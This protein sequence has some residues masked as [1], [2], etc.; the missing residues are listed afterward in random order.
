MLLGRKN[1]YK[2]LEK[3]LGYSFRKRAFLELALMHRSF[4]F[5]SEAVGM[6]NQRLEFLGD[7]VLGF[8]AAEYL[9]EASRDMDEGGLTAFRSRATSGKTLARLAQDV[10]LGDYIKIGKGEE[11]T[12]GRTRPSNLEDALESVLGA[13][14]LDG[15]MK[16][17]RKIF[18]RVFVPAMPDLSE[19]VWAGNPKG[20]LQEC[21]QRVWKRSPLYRIVTREGPPHAALFT[22]EVTIGEGLRGVGKGR[23]KQEAE[24][25]AAR[26]LL[27]QLPDRHRASP[28]R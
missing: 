18:Q 6:D 3:R 2:D 22:A 16:A 17:V 27:E 26:D 7:A 19:D 25:G 15:G 24:A 1:P 23:N 4:R 9:F 21:A 14:Y 5:E 28:D 20:K 12:G 11:K 13:A 10:R 8:I